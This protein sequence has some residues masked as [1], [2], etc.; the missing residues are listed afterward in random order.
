[1]QLSVVSVKG[2]MY[3]VWTSRMKYRAKTITRDMREMVA[4]GW[5][6]LHCRGRHTALTCIPCMNHEHNTVYAYIV[7]I[8]PT[9]TAR[10]V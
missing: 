10:A 4:E 6:V 9:A 2:R 7:H 8:L 5:S 1:M 3:G